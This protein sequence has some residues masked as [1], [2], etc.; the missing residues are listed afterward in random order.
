M[1]FDIKRLSPEKRLL[2]IKLTSETLLPSPVNLSE[3]EMVS[4]TQMNPIR[5]GE[6]RGTSFTDLEDFKITEW[7]LTDEYLNSF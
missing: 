5:F 3:S 1:M 7:Q 4:T 2:I 6:Y